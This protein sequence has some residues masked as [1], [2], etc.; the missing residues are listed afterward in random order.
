MK[1]YLLP[2]AV[3]LATAVLLFGCAA[4][5]AYARGKYGVRAPATTGHPQF[6]I[7]YRIQMNTLEN[8]VAFLPLLW[9]AAVYA[10]PRLAGAVGLIWLAARIGYAL[11]YARAPARRGPGFTVA[12]AAAVALGVAAGIGMLRTALA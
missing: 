11:A 8:A 2:A 10:G 5:V 3:T 9:L 12:L 6:E 7:A 4:Y 1:E